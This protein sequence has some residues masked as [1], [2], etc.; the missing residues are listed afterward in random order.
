M[1]RHPIIKNDNLYYFYPH[2]MLPNPWVFTEFNRLGIEDIVAYKYEVDSVCLSL[3]DGRLVR[4][5][6]RASDFYIDLN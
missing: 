1:R 3:E 5:V 2:H 4:D 6:K